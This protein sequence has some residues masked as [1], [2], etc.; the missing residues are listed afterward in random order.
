MNNQRPPD[1]VKIADI[2]LTTLQD[3]LSEGDNQ[4]REPLDENTP[5]L[6]RRSDLDSVGLVRLVVDL[7]QRLEEEYYVSEYY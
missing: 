6:G 2:V 7:E 4:P 1:R 3:A 5:L